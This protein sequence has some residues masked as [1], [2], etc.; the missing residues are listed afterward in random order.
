MPR[1]INY[2]K[3]HESLLNE[4]VRS[5]DSSG[6]FETKA[7]CLTYAASFGASFGPE[8]GRKSLP[9]K[10]GES[11][12]YD[13]FHSPDFE[14]L[15]CTLAVFATKD[16]NVLQDDEDATDKRVTIFEEFA[17]CG[18]E[19]LEAELKGEA[20]KT[21]GIALLLSKNFSDRVE[22]EGINWEKIENL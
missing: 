2:A 17:N 6:P 22:E 1:R 11:I 3:S 13:V 5:S 21:D 18:L 9:E 15:I 19:R 14:D 4:L 12:R 7:R 20:N 16:I 8:K 10:K